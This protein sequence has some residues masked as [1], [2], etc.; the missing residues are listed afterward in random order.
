MELRRA[1]QTEVARYVEFKG[2]VSPF[3]QYRY[4]VLGLGVGDLGLAR[5]VASFPID[6]KNWSR[7]DFAITYRVCEMLGV[8]QDARAPKATYTTAEQAFLRALDAVSRG[9]AYDAAEVH[10]FWKTLRKKRYQFT[11]FEQKDLFTPA[12]ETLRAA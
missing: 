2:A 10:A 9:E 6:R 1:I 11:I 4:L 12:L 8:S 5:E 7:F 3:L